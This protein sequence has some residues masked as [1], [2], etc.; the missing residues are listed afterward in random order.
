MW[1]YQAWWGK[2]AGAPQHVCPPHT[3]IIHGGIGSRE[4]KKQL[5]QRQ[6]KANLYLGLY[7][8]W[9]LLQ[10]QAHLLFLP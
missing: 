4:R 5:H 2:W 9:V 1:G 7:A 6:T 8:L 10:N 3:C